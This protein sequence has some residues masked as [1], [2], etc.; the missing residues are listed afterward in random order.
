MESGD[1][2]Q[3]AIEGLDG[4]DMGGRN[5]KVNIA[6]DRPKRERNFNS[7]QRRSW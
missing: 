5:L 3:A 1:A 2:A 6:Q 4:T 7:G